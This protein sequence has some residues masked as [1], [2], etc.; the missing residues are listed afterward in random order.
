[1]VKLY[2]LQILLIIFGLIIIG[3]LIAR[4]Y[5]VRKSFA[6]FGGFLALFMGKRAHYSFSMLRYFT[7]P[8]LGVNTFDEFQKALG[9][10]IQRIQY[11]EIEA[12][13]KTGDLI[14]I[15]GPNQE[16]INV[17]SKW[18]G[19]TCFSHIGMVVKYGDELKLFEASYQFSTVLSPL[20]NRLE[21]Y[22]TELIAVRHL[23]KPLTEEM[24]KIVFEF[25]ME[26]VGTTHEGKNNL[27]GGWEM[28]KAALDVKIPFTKID[29]FGNKHDTDYLFCSEAVAEL[30]MR[31]GLL[32]RG[33]GHPPSNEYIPGDFTNTG[34]WK[35]DER[36]NVKNLLNG[37]SL[38]PE[39]YLYPMIPSH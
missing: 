25:V 17:I 20:R 26:F 38:S 36:K 19:G 16:P 14:F 7:P 28:F 35:G 37:Y 5:P 24:K 6:V 29:L 12:E 9:D 8:H 31:I 13:L 22:P 39:I 30:Y 18:S 32:P 2:N 3:F 11:D 33:K 23:N 15:S 21:Y 1:M 34:A 4:P 10:E 27:K